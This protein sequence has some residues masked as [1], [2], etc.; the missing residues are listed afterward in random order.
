MTTAET[1]VG[2]RRFWRSGWLWRGI[3]CCCVLCVCL[4]PITFGDGTQTPPWAVGLLLALT[5]AGLAAL[6]AGWRGRSVRA[7]L[8]GY[9]MALPVG[10]AGLLLTLRFSATTVLTLGGLGLLGAGGLALLAGKRFSAGNGETIWLLLLGGWMRFCYVLCTSVT[11]RQHDVGDFVGNKGHAGYILYLYQHGHLPDFDVREVW[12]YYHPPLH[13][14]R[15]AIWLHVWEFLGVAHDAACESLQMLTLCDSWIALLLMAWLFRYFHLHGRAFLTALA[16]VALHPTFFLLAGSVN[17]DMLSVLFFLG[18]LV[19][20]LSWYRKPCLWR[21]VAA[22]LCM[23]LGMM[24]KLSVWMAAVPLAV[25]FLARFCQMQKGG[26]RRL[27]GQA[28]LFLVLCA[29]LAL[30]WEVRNAV[31]FGVPI[32][33]VPELPLDSEQYVGNI[34]PWKRLL[35]FSWKQFYHVGM[36]FVWYGG[37]YFEWNP[38][39]GLWK[40]AVFDELVTDVFYPQIHVP[41]IVLFWSSVLLS[42]AGTAAVLRFLGTPAKAQRWQRLALLLLGMG[43][44]LNYL[45]FCLVYPHTCTQNIRYVVPLIPIGALALGMLCRNW[46]K[47]AG[48]LRRICVLGVQGLTFLFCLHAVL[49]YAI[50][51]CV[52]ES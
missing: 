40:T 15:C 39:I 45:I 9:G 46:A 42:L 6:I 41:A 28:A 7:N 50:V 12:Q 10:I 25:L 1:G 51:A 4:T 43:L 33:Y 23:G 44:F 11:Q 48:R 16:L 30:W 22:A 13:H 49:V 14:I 47:C 5:Y 8:L 35:D 31:K 3:V 2:E 32:A 18:T 29:P 17:N 37:D 27:V 52:G 21:M 34:A 19:A 26:H 20:G 24:T 36:Q 38:T